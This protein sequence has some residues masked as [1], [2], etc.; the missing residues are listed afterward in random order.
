MKCFLRKWYYRYITYRVTMK[1][2]SNPTSN[3]YETE[4]TVEN[5]NLYAKNII[6]KNGQ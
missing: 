6:A 4:Q 5:I 2:L 1:Y 3:P